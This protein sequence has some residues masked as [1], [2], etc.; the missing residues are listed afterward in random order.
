M[1]TSIAILL[2]I[3][4]LALNQDGFDNK[5]AEPHTRYDPGAATG[6]QRS[7]GQRAQPMSL[8]PCG[9][10]SRPLIRN[11]STGLAQENKPPQ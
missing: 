3:G 6:G 1:E 9:N 5:S 10:R 4:A 11:L 8:R 2:L 7:C